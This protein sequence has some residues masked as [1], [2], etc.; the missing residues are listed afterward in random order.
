MLIWHVIKHFQRHCQERVNEIFAN[1]FAREKEFINL[2][3]LGSGFRSKQCSVKFW[4]GSFADGLQ[5][6]EKG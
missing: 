2:V 5:T 6:L 1:L 3:F 4:F